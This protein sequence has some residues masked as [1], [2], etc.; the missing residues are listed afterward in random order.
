MVRLD[1]GTTKNRDGRSFPFTAAL[2]ALLTDQLAEHDRLKAT[3][4]S[5]DT[6]ST[7]TGTS[8]ATSAARGKPRA[9]R[10]AGTSA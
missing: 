7:G 2:E 8:F 3:A 10:P 1:P 9:R 6:S 4:G 5:F